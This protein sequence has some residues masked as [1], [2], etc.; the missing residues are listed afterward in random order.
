MPVVYVRVYTVYSIRIKRK[1]NVVQEKYFF[2][3]LENRVVN[4]REFE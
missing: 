3:E 1:S 4:E 2:I